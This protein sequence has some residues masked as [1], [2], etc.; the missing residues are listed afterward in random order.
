M[1]PTTRSC[2]FFG[3]LTL[4]GLLGGC[5]DTTRAT[6]LRSELSA[7]PPLGTV[8]LPARHDGISFQGSASLGLAATTTANLGIV[9]ESNALTLA[10]P[11]K[12]SSFIGS[13][14]Q[15]RQDQVVLSGEAS[16]FFSRFSRLFL[17]ASQGNAYWVGAGGAAGKEWMAEGD[18]SIGRIETR[19]R[20]VWNLETTDYTSSSYG[21]TKVRDTLVARS[22]TSM[23]WRFD[24]SF[25][26][27]KGGP[28]IA[29]Q[30]LR[31]TATTSPTDVE[32]ASSIHTT[33]VGW[34][35]PLKAG[36]LAAFASLTSLGE[37]WSPMARIQYTLDLGG[38]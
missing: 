30:F 7:T 35:E 25:A 28:V 36:T 10:S 16:V 37:S 21:T 26:R 8:R 12:D 29:Y 6:L 24:L 9:K 23:F 17:G 34:F 15:L 3:L 11:T 4:S 2:A 27:R 20:E 14:V 5:A 1:R 31:M 33:T 13:G 18:I 38:K 22:D 32:Y 19:R